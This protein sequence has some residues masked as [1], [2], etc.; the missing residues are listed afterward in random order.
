M[1]SL[2]FIQDL[3]IIMMTAGSVTLLFREF[4]QPVVLGYLVAGLIIG[5]HTPP[6]M[7]VTNRGTIQSL[8]E[9]GIIFL[10]FS[11][12]LHFNL[13]K[14]RTVGK[15]AVVTALIEIVAMTVIGFGVGRAFSW[16]TTDSLFL[17]AILSISS[18]TIIVK[19][20][21]ELKLTG[22][23]F[24]EL[25]FGIL[26]VEDI[27]GVAVMA[28]LSAIAMTDEIS[29]YEFGDTIGR[30]VIFLVAT[31]GIGRWVVSPI[32]RYVTTFR[33]N[34]GTLVVA[35]GLCFSSSFLAMK[36]GYSSALGAFIMGVVISETSGIDKIDHLV[37]PLRDMFSAIFFVAVGMMIN[38]SEIVHY[39]WP[40]LILTGVVIV[41]KALTCSIGTRMAGNPWPVSVKVGL[42]LTQ[43]GEFSFI[44]A[45]L[46]TT[47]K[48]TSEFLYPIAVAVSA[49]TTFTT[50]YL[51][52]NSEA[53]GRFWQKKQATA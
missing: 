14:L 46:G 9:V 45:T 4:R 28:L 26:I 13:G 35:L 11:L 53:I 43:I 7:L 5:P 37:E 20:L 2:S 21:Q 50:P 6:F 48:V 27:L 32:F 22:Q 10:M 19:A 16:N 39:L 15:T 36:L 8:A 40:I 23:H 30:L 25:I 47:L 1:H 29:V 24:S 42:G 17:G 51:I 12:G 38:P 49:I 44:I 33:S 18:T 34:E 3:A 31:L 52:R 41:G